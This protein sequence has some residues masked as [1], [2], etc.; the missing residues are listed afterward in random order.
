[1]GF[2]ALT[3]AI[4]LI[5][6]VGQIFSWPLGIVAYLISQIIIYLTEFSAQIPFATLQ[7]GAIPLWLIF[8]WYVFYGSI[9]WK[10]RRAP[11]RST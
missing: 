1:M 5:P 7:T 2:G 10:L 3:G 8:I 11:S 9:Y 6:L 4:G